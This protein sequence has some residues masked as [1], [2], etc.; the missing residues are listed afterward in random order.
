MQFNNCQLFQDG[1]GELSSQPVT[2]YYNS[3][4]VII[5]AIEK[6]N[7]KNMTF[8]YSNGK[9]SRLFSKTLEKSH[10]ISNKH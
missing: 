2:R 1:T 7:L 8:L 10:V 3:E 6:Q 4:M 5:I 9:K